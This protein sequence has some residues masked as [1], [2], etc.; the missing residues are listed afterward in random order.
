[1]KRW[2]TTAEAAGLLGV[3]KGTIKRW[4][5]S[6][7]QREALLAVRHGKQWR[8]PL[9]DYETTWEW[10]T[11][12]RLK[13]AGVHLKSSWAQEL[14]RLSKQCDRFLSESYCLWLAAHLQL[15]KREKIADEDI[16]EIISLWQTACEI[17]RP[18]PEG[19]KVDKLK[20]QF[21]ESLRARKFSEEDIRSIMSYWPDESCFK[22]V[23]A[24]RTFEQ[25]EEI[26]R[27]VDVAE[28]IKACEQEGKKPTAENLR[29]LLHDDIMA[30]IN[31]TREKLPGIVFKPRT[32]DE[33]R[34]AVEADACI[35][36]NSGNPR[37][38]TETRDAQGRT[39]VHIQ[40]Q[41]ANQIIDFREPQDGLALRTFRNRHPLRKSPQREIVATVYGARDSIPGA[42]D[43]PCGRK[44]PVRDSALSD[45][46]AQRGRT[47]R[48][49]S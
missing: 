31:D 23:R 1:M 17:L 38:F 41:G 47:K 8:I 35:Q 21:P 20:S 49:R 45:E 29:P 9:P 13:E 33:L 48:R 24:A 10:Q 12:S 36:M 6:P 5:K 43:Q 14:H 39:H 40:G 26:R 7:P 27:G 25:L 4:M 15:L 34:R 30:H 19:T 3:S 28:A 46:R 32:P 42:D 37:R 2:L 44:T 11:R 18:L 22:R 16:G